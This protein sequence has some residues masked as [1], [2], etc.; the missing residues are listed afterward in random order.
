MTFVLSPPPKLYCYLAELFI[1][2]T[3]QPRAKHRLLISYIIKA[4]KKR[5]QSF[6][7]NR[8]DADYV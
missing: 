4:D 8:L 6:L 3:L 5:R 7:E 2:V 1:N